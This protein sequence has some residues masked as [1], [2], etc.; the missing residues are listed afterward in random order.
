MTG[1]EDLPP[2]IPW[3]PTLSPS[4]P[5]WPS[6]SYDK[7][8]FGFL[9]FGEMEDVQHFD[10]SHGQEFD[11]DF[12]VLQGGVH[13]DTSLA[14]DGL[15]HPFAGPPFFTEYEHGPGVGPYENSMGDTQVEADAWLRASYSVA[16]SQANQ[17]YFLSPSYP[18]RCSGPW[19][20]LTSVQLIKLLSV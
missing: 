3:E 16:G 6:A 18:M 2:E 8:P 14:Q 10:H 17:V 13:P 15:M 4:S 12:E 20:P 5:E 19:D 11:P 7:I 9:E 1:E